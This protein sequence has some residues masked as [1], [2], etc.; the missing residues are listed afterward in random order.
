MASLG[1]NELTHWGRVPHICVGKTTIIGSDNGLSPGQRQ[2][3]IWTNAGILL[4]GTL[5]TNFGEILIECHSFPFKKMHKKMS[6]GKWRPSWL[7]LIGLTHWGLATHI[8]SLSTGSSLVWEMVWH[9]IGT[10]PFPE[11]MKTYC[12]LYSCKTNLSEILF[13]LKNKFLNAFLWM[14][15]CILNV[16]FTAICPHWSTWK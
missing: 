12:E 15:V 14:E 3:I 11:P 13:I 10:K 6:S 5:G 2:A 9:L 16:D 1:H 4:I 7:G 8:I